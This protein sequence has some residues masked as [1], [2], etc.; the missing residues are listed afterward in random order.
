[1][2][3]SIRIGLS[4]KA[5]C[6]K[7]TFAE[8]LRTALDSQGKNVVV[9]SFAHPIREVA[10]RVG[11]DPYSRERKEQ[12]V[13]LCYGHFELILIDALVAE[14][15]DVVSEEALA[16]LYATFI[17][18]LRDSGYLRTKRRDELNISPRRFC[19][20][21]GTEGGRAVRKS[22][23]NDVLVAR[24][25]RLDY[26]KKL[27]VVIVTDVRFP[28]EALV[29]DDVVFIHRAGLDS[30]ATHES[31]SHYDFLEGEAAFVVDNDSTL[32]ALERDA[33][34]LAEDYR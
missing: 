17:T 9:T 10:R 14:L 2:T 24:C 31:E 4:G 27:D 15:S 19:Q 25:K 3:R 28:D 34:Q 20:L 21:L 12:D 11:L 8:Y 32:D 22:F 6:G 29:V 30:V 18:V 13:Q 23:W 5:G 1:M 7:D 16:D 33:K 26:Q